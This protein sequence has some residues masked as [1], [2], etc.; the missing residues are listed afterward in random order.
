MVPS[1]MVQTRSYLS[2]V[3]YKV[4]NFDLYRPYPVRQVTG[5]RTARYRAV[6]SKIDR[7]R[8]ISAVSGRL[9]KK[10]TVAID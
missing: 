5:T 8:S 10:L 6:P 9:K 4:C 2:S 3:G 7:R 1:D